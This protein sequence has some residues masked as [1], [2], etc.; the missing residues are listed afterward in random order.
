MT[1]LTDQELNEAVAR[2]LGKRKTYGA[3]PAPFNP[4]GL[5]VTIQ[6]GEL[7]DYCHSIAAAWEIVEKRKE[8]KRD[9]ILMS[10]YEFPGWCCR[11]TDMVNG[12]LIKVEG[13]ADTAPLAIC[14]AFLK[15]D[16]PVKQ[17]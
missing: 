14:L 7:P 4:K 2:K 11:L 16:K 9:F 3:H 5:P 13:H 12:V 1:E 8:F 6:E 15:L 17:E 10:S